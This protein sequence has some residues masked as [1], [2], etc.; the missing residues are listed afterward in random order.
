MHNPKLEIL[1]CD[2][3]PHLTGISS[4]DSERLGRW[5]KLIFDMREGKEDRDQHGFVED[6]TPLNKSFAYVRNLIF[7]AFHS[8]STQASH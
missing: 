5:I 1:G 4:Q 7:K 3:L 8:N 2:N 6:A